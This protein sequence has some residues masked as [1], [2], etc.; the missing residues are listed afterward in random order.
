MLDAPDQDPEPFLETQH[1]SITE[2]RAETAAAFNEM[3]HLAAHLCQT[4]IAALC[5]TDRQRQWCQSSHGVPIASVQSEPS[6]MTRGLEH[7]GVL[8]VP[9][10][11]C[12]AQLAANRLGVDSHPL[13]FYASVPMTDSKGSPVGALVVLD[14]LPRPA[15]LT[16]EQ[17]LHLQSLARQASSF[18]ELHR[19][20]F[21]E[22]ASLRE[23]VHR[24]RNVISVAQALV[25]RTLSST[26]SHEKAAST[27]LGRLD[28]LGSVQD[29][30]LADGQEGADLHAMVIRQLAPFIDKDDPRL[31][32]QGPPTILRASAA[33]AI[34][35]AVH[36]LATNATKHG[37]LSDDKGQISIAWE[38]SEG[39]DLL[40]QWSE[41]RANSVPL[42][43]VQDKGFGSFVLGP[44]TAE[45]ID[46]K[47]GLE[48]RPEG[49]SWSATIAQQL[50]LRCG[51]KGEDDQTT[52]SST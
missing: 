2:L 23:S 42:P 26:D 46:G 27:L 49:A 39:G 50:V 16:D 33:E 35:M 47:A 41:K 31:K 15:G 48:L 38:Q 25:M 6:L 8:V 28:A 51:E 1:G 18:W 40:V 43:P 36:E 13:G 22:R 21:R 3:T 19:A 5:L 10:A 14:H 17:S 4:S 20:L 52:S 37:A 44:L 9:D 12:D 24:T 29:I 30:L 32:L 45:R 7:S 11:R 34:G